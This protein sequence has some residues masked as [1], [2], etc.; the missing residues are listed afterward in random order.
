MRCSRPYPGGFTL[1]QGAPDLLGFSAAELTRV[2]L[3][4]PPIGF[5]GGAGFFILELLLTATA[6]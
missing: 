5:L 1:S 2:P 4:R 3:F 6:R